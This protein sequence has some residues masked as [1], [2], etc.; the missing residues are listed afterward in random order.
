MRVLPVVASGIPEPSVIDDQDRWFSRRRSN[1][2][3][4]HSLVHAWLMSGLC[5][6]SMTLAMFAVFPA[7]V[8]PACTTTPAAPAPWIAPA[9]CHA[10]MAS[11]PSEI[12]RATGIGRPPIGPPPA[13]ARL[14]ARR[15]AEVVA[16]HNLALKLGLPS[17]TR[18]RGFRYLPPIYHP[19]GRVEVTVE[20][21][22][23]SVS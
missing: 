20:W 16:V 19:D 6:R 5:P 22:T 23:G 11:C 3:Q 17:G 2:Y 14:M 18:V 15:A 8:I 21:R 9:C 10:P 13:Q 12:V 4:M 7:P 1:M